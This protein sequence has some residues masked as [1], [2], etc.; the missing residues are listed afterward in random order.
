MK[1]FIPIQLGNNNDA[2]DDGGVD[3]NVERGEAL[4]V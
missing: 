3:N 1:A 4:F 2:D